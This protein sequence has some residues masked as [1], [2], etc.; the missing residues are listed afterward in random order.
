MCNPRRVRVTATREIAEAWQQQVRR[1][2]QRTGRADG[3]VRIREPLG[4]TIGGPTL[5]A[6]ATVLAGSPGWERDGDAYRHEL[7][8]G[9]VLYDP[10]ARELEIVATAT[11]DVSVSI[12]ATTTAAG[13]LAEE[14]RGEGEGV[15]YDDEWQGVTADDAR[16]DAEQNAAA[17][18]DDAARRRLDR[19]RREID[20]REGAQVQAE[21]E[22][23]A[24]AALS[25]AAAE[26]SVQLRDEAAARL[27]ATGIEGRNLFYQ[28]LG[29]AYRDAIMAFARNRGAEGLRCTESDGIVDIEFELDVN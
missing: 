10:A 5:A 22:A 4:T 18:L 17:A 29:A 16:R 2:A 23:E 6:L 27:T 20:E 28:A 24:D 15:Y 19:A 21:A 14:V 1:R 9:Y 11:A 13:E 7:E 8:H 25:E 26:R 3:E 12:E